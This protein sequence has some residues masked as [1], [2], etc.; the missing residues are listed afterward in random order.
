MVGF[1]LKIGLERLIGL[2][3][4]RIEFGTVALRGTTAYRGW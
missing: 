4:L 3:L 1:V 2:D